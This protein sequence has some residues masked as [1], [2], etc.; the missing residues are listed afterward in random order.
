MGYNYYGWKESGQV[1]SIDP[2]YRGIGTPRDLY[3]LLVDI[4]CAETCAPRLRKNWSK[5]NKTLGQC[6][7]TAF[8]VQDIF[9]GEVYAMRTGNGLHCYNRIQD[10]VFDL[11]SEQFGEKAAE[12]VYNCELL[13]DRESADHFQ[14]DEK[15]ARY[16]YLSEQLKRKL[17]A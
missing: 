1:R 10:A 13:Q 16:V 7:I 4:W 15:R 2:E 5:E 6:S 12:L 17:R 9:G 3:D 11:T 8:L 14:K